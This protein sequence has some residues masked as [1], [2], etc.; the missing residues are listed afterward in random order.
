M[1]HFQKCY[2]LDTSVI[3]DD[4]ANILKISQNNQNLVVVTNIVLAELNAKKDDMRSDAGFRAREFFRL[5]DDAHGS[6][7]G[8]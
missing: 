6:P 1:T 4:P 7:I 2:L 8:K 5:A 3:L